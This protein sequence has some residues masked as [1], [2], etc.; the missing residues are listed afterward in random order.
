MIWNFVCAF[1]FLFALQNFVNQNKK[2]WCRIWKCALDSVTEYL[3]E[4]QCNRLGD[5]LQIRNAFGFLRKIMFTFH[6]IFWEDVL[7]PNISY[8]DG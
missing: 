5:I 8:R 1:F 6:I 3:H 4:K 2:K 7:C